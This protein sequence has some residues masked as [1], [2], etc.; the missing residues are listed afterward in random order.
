MP[1][2]GSDELRVGAELTILPLD[3]PSILGGLAA[4]F[5]KLIV[6]IA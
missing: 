6:D 2:H 3:R 5:Q 1:R 4:E